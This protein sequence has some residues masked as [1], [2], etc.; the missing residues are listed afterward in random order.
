MNVMVKCREDSESGVVIIILVNLG[1]S[2]CRE[3][4]GLLLNW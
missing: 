2:S 4:V 3:L 1:S